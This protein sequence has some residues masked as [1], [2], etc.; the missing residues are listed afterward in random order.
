MGLR[1]DGRATAEP[2]E[3]GAGDGEGGLGTE[4]WEMG[5]GDG[6][7][8]LLGDHSVTSGFVER[9]RGGSGRGAGVGAVG[10]SEGGRGLKGGS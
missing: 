1:R 8:G 4:G 10:L 6:V 2:V 7:W 9:D 5:A 3:E